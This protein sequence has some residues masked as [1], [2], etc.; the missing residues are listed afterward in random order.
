MKFGLTGAL[1]TAVLSSGA[2]A[3]KPWNRF[4]LPYGISQGMTEAEFD[5][6]VAE[7]KLTVSYPIGGDTKS[8]KFDDTEYWL[9]FCNG[10]L[11]YASWTIDTNDELIKSM[12]ERINEQGFT[13]ANMTVASSYSDSRKT[14]DNTLRMRLVHPEKAYSVTYQLFSTNGQITLEDTAHDDSFGCEGD[15]A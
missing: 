5:E 4:W 13:L 1:L 15:P 8:I 2:V 9:N 14:D 3:Q 11:T 10:K 7:N 12:N 6:K